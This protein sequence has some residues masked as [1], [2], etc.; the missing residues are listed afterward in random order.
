MKALC[1]GLPIGLTYARINKEMFPCNQQ[2]GRAEEVFL[3][4]ARG[5]GG[6]WCVWGAASRIGSDLR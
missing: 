5:S 1:I 4:F 2:V 6:V 3:E